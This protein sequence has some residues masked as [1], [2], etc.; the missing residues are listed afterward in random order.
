ML[1]YHPARD[2]YP[3]MLEA[4]DDA[5]SATRATFVHR[6]ASGLPARPI[7]NAFALLFRSVAA[8][9]AKRKPGKPRRSRSFPETRPFAAAGSPVACGEN[10]VFLQTNRQTGGVMR[11]L[12]VLTAVTAL[13]TLTV[14]ATIKS[15]APVAPT[16]APGQGAR[17][18][19][20]EIQRQIDVMDCP[21]PWL[22]SPIER[23][24]GYK[25]MARGD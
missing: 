20:E 3:S 22:T 10:V 24:G 8:G 4:D 17:I 15:L 23:P 6:L 5:G 2:G 13:A 21:L 18:S 25:A 12:I 1:L 7:A 16:T 9:A 11:K 19:P 14:A